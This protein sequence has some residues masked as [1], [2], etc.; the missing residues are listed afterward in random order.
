MSETPTHF[1]VAPHPDDEIIGCYE[2][3]NNPENKVAVMYSG[4]VDQKRREEALHL[5]EH[6]ENVSIQMF[7]MSIPPPMLTDKNLIFYVPDPIYE[8][9]PVHRAWGVAGESMARQGLNV[10]FY[11]TL[12]NAPYIHEVT[13]SHKETLL[14]FV[15]P[16]Q[17]D[18]WK[19]E[20]KFILFEGRCK[21]LF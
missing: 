6:R 8:I 19:Y 13:D 3:I 11:S 12:M 10:V 2:I 21:W 14:D 15:Y 4:D 17:R 20:K 18:L 16:S 5:R 7:Q 9:H 1:I